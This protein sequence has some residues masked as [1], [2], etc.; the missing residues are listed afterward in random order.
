[1]MGKPKLEWRGRCP[2]SCPRRHK[3]P[4]LHLQRPTARIQGFPHQTASS[5]P[6][7][8]VEP[9]FT[10]VVHALLCGERQC[11]ALQHRTTFDDNRKPGS[12]APSARL[13][14]AV[15]SADASGSA[16][17]AMFGAV[18]GQ[19]PG[20]AF[21]VAGAVHDGGGPKWWRKA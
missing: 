18:P 2:P 16:S 1:M 14:S 9:I 15:A 7:L 8:L 21:L 19:A 11:T 17:R 5:A 3:A 20:A 10:S 6:I 12:I 4:G 13:P